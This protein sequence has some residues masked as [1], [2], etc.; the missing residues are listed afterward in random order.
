MIGSSSTWVKPCAERVVGERVGELVVAG[1]P[2]PVGDRAPPR[3]EVD[4]VDRDRCVERDPRPAGRHPLGVVPLVGQVGDD[5]VDRRRLAGRRRERIALV[6]AARPSGAVISEVV[7]GRRRR[8]RPTQP[9]PH[10][11][12]LRPGASAHAGRSAKSPT[13]STARAFGAHTANRHAAVRPACAPST[14]WSR[15]CVPSLN[16]CRSS[17]PGTSAW[18]ALARV[19]RAA[20]DVTSEPLDQLGR[21]GAAATPTHS[22]RCPSS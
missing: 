12:R 3:A 16:R 11:R 4:L 5:R 17:S 14:S 1:E 19:G 6:A 18:P 21:G 15:R 10:A 7:R 8:R 20:H 13:T 22:G 2:P 9:R